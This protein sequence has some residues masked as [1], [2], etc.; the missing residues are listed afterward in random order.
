MHL[1]S[2]TEVDEMLHKFISGK[3]PEKTIY[4]PWLFA[5][6]AV[7]ALVALSCAGCAF[8]SSPPAREIKQMP[9]FR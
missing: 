1:P 7:G 3:H 5:G 4:T 2:K 6:I 8:N 9:W